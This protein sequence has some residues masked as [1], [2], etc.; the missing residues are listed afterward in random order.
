[1]KDTLCIDGGHSRHQFGVNLVG[2]HA[3]TFI[4]GAIVRL[5]EH[6]TLQ[7]CQIRKLFINTKFTGLQ[8]CVLNVSSYMT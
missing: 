7:C 5:I 3:I 1:M 8:S 6:N 2:F 4:V